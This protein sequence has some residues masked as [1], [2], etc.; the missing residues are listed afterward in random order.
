M[1]NTALDRNMLYGYIIWLTHWK[2]WCKINH[3]HSEIA[4]NFTYSMSPWTASVVEN[5]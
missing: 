2:Q 4:I 5:M 1:Q 3:F